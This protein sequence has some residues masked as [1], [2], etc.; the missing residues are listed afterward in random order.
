MVIFIIVMSFNKV[1][2]PIRDIMLLISVVIILIVVVGEIIPS[3]DQGSVREACSWS[4]VALLLVLLPH[5]VTTRTNLRLHVMLLSSI[6]SNV[7]T[8]RKVVPSS[9]G[10]VRSVAMVYR[11]CA[12]AVVLGMSGSAGLAGLV[13]GVVI[14]RHRGAVLG[15][16]VGREES[17]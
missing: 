10:L 13:A 12:A 17:S 1:L 7:T 6:M 14:L 9:S 8:D 16:A 15:V 5:P 2:R 4:Q 11:L 3:T